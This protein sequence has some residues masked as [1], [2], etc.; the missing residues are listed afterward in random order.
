LTQPTTR[1]DFLAA[2][3]AAASAA[4]LAPSLYAKG[5]DVL[6]VGL[7]GCGNRGTG[8]AEQALN[9]DKNVKL[10]A[11]GD[12]FED[13]LAES[14]KILQD[15][16]IAKKLEVPKERQ[17]TGFDA[18][19]KVIACDVDVVLLT[20]PPGFRPIH[21]RAAVEAGKHVFCEKPMAVDGPGVRSVMESVKIAKEK[22]RSIV[23]GFCY[24]YHRAKREWM[25]RVHGGDVGKVVALQCVYHTGG[26][27]NY[28][29]KKDMDDMTFQLRN[30]LYYTWLSG[31]HIVEQACHSIDKMAWVMQDEPPVSCVG[32]GGRQYRTGPEF[33]HIFDHHS[34]IYTYK[35]GVKL[36]HSCRQ[37]D[38]TAKQTAD[39]VFG[40]EGTAEI[41]SNQFS[42]WAHKISGKKSWVGPR[43]EKEADNPYQNEHNELFASI[44][45]GK[46]IN[47]GEWMAKSTLMAIM[48]RMATYTGQEIT[49]EKALAS[50][51]DWSPKK[52]EFGPLATPAVA[53]PGAT[54]FF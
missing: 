10:V 39:W 33:G 40:S 1:R 44:R 4:A 24:R 27:W 47:D 9:A 48:G 12:M 16:P 29:R 41:G 18:Y 20:T 54:E 35:S 26:L 46:R 25:K 21:L 32:L 31:D 53:R 51:Q 19:K 15:K 13:K 22:D 43:K 6:K 45:S 37:Q 5:D 2:S 8:A 50:K 28:A 23:A 11:M 30:W 42:A 34:V 3:A 38:G 36:F 14:L 52:Y 17:F 49:W 7:I